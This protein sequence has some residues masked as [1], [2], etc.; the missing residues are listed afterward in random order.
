MTMR[1]TRHKLE[2]LVAFESSLHLLSMFPHTHFS[3][4]CEFLADFVDS[5]TAKTGLLRCCLCSFQLLLE[6]EFDVVIF[7]HYSDHCRLATC[8]GAIS[9]NFSESCNT[10]RSDTQPQPHIL[11]TVLVADAQSSRTTRVKLF[12]EC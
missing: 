9:A 6:S 4:V 5:H 12:W 2:P 3:P 8:A 1:R 11:Q 10:M 7:H